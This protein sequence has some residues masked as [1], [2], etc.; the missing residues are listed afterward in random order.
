MAELL[1]EPLA[2]KLFADQDLI[3]AAV[4]NRATR[5]IINR[6][7]YQI[8][9][10]WID[11]GVRGFSGYVAPFQPGQTPCYD[12]CFDI[13]SQSSEP[14]PGAGSGPGAVGVTASLIGSLEADLAV[15]HLLGLT[16]PLAGQILYYHGRTLDFMRIAI[17]KRADCPICGGR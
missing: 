9:K 2:N 10:T 15:N 11:G 7:C 12:C 16:M 13:D 14:Q 5:Q 3:V 4:D 1:T 17:E 8:G 6:V